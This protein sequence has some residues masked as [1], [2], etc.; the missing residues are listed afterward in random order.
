MTA[1]PDKVRIDKWLWAARFFK[2]RSQATEAI[3]G[4]KV[5]ING[6]RVKPSRS[7]QIADEIAVTRGPYRTVVR[8]L[9]LSDRRGP[10]T[11]AALLYQ[12]TEQ[13]QVARDALREQLRAE[14]SGFSDMKGR[15]TKKA[16]RQIIK[17]IRHD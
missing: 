15:P 12:E 8:V 16:R 13:S 1:T 6:Q 4:G 11:E 7:V 9:A 2:T 17:F 3:D 10:A 14:N 5:H